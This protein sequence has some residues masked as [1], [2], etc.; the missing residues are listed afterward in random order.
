VATPLTTDLPVGDLQFYDNYIPGLIAG[1]EYRITVGH[2]LD[3]VETGVLSATQHLAVSAPQFAMDTTTVLNQYPPGGSTG[4]YAHVLPHI[5]LN[6]P[7]LPWERPLRA[8]GRPPWLALLVL[9]EDEIIGGDG[10]PTR[11]QTGTVNSFLSA[12]PAVLKPAVTP[13]VDITGTDPC[14]FIQLATGVFPALTPRLTELRFLAHCRQSNVSDKAE[15][16]LEPNGLFSVVVGNRFPAT[17]KAGDVGAHKSIAHLVSLEGLEPYLVEQPGFGAYTSVA[18][19]SL[20][21]WTFNTVA[22]QLQD[23][24]GL[25]ENLVGHE[26][27]GTTYAPANLWLRLP[28]P[29]IDT[30]TPAGAEASHRL[31]DGFVPLSYQFRT[32]EHTFAW[33]RGPCVP[34]LTTPLPDG[35][36]FATS[37]SALIY[38]D[39]FGVFDGSL[40]T[41]WQTGR[42]LALADRAFGQ[43]L[44]DF[45]QR[46]HRLTDSLLQRLRSD[47]FSASQ[48]SELRSN[49]MVQDEFLRYLSADLLTS[50]GSATATATA[51][52]PGPTPLRAGPRSAPDPDPTTAVKNFLADPRVPALIAD[53]TQA[54]LVPVAT[55]L[56]NL[57]LL[58]PVPFNVL[59]PDNRMLTPETLRFFYLDDTWLRA[60]TDGAVSIGLQSSRDSFFTEIMGDLVFRAANTAAQAIRAR[61]IGVDPPAV[62]VSEN[63]VSGF[64]LRSAVVSG[65]PNLAVRGGPTDGGNLRILRLDR[66]ADDVLIGLFWGVPN[67]VEF[68]EP[69]EGF[70]FGTDDDGYL[71]IRQ[72]LAGGAQPLGTQ[73]GPPLP[74]T[75]RTGS[76]VVDVNTA[77]Q[78]VN[79]ALSAA[80]V[81]VPDF[82]PG[83][84]A[85]QMVKSPEAIRFTSQLH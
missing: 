55:W 46:G 69:Q 74:L 44:Y 68:A 61:R 26:Y 50:L 13:A 14:H 79:D 16:G 37:D 5:V 65:W 15:Q 24:R 85:L 83:D 28:A 52:G 78:Q 47:A 34:V 17:P 51:T 18:L 42:S 43:A 77:V 41:A 53:E 59:V 21:S 67:Y 57:L 35:T 54:D 8:P 38:Q 31:V 25:M 56:A 39:E 73:L 58:Y 7:L 32:G 29:P 70:R 33:Y 82:G 45:R 81:A 12:D 71:P 36:R 23:F 19:V 63:L 11:T 62:E 2:T 84:F 30:S 75:L 9:G 48:I 49:T 6:D 66:L 72:P 1:H 40:A 4:Q 76:T 22:D 64:L 80:Q 10:S 20:A 27:D 3:G 60:L